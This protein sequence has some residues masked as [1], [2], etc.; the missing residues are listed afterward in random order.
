M[1]DQYEA[2][3]FDCYGTLIDWETGIL[4]GLQ[5]IAAKHPN[6]SGDDLLQAYARFE[7]K[8]EH[9]Q[10]GL[11]Y[12]RLVAEVYRQLAAEM[13]VPA[14]AAEA[15]G[16]SVG[17]WPAFADTTAALQRLKRRFKLFIL[18]NVDNASIGR[19]IQLMGVPFD[20]VFTAQDIGSY[21]PDHRNFHYAR[22]RLA[23][24]GIPAE[25]HLHVA[26]SLFHDHEPC[27]A[28]GIPS[29]WIDRRAAKGQGGAVVTPVQLPPVL[30]TY[31]TLMAFAETAVS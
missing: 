2:L 16:G 23:A 3:T 18:S 30:A 11:R 14:D 13:G 12:D 4:A 15:F 9:E 20:G 19:S 25:R 26:Q 8:V 24:Q 6:L 22:E 5:P 7:L 29:V 28:L 17:A 10:P 21:K 1:Y 31:P 27:A